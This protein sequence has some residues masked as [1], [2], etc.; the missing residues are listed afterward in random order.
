MKLG[1]TLGWP[2]DTAAIGPAVSRISRLADEA[3]VDSIWITDHFFQIPVTELPREAPML[4][5]YATLAYILGQTRQIHVGALVTCPVYRHPG[6]LLK[7]LTT[8]DVLSG[9]RVTFGIGAGWHAEE[10]RALGIPF[11]PLR[12]RYERLEETLQIAHQM[13][14]GDAS[15]FDGKHYQLAEPINSP[16]AVERPRILIAGGGETKTLRL[17]ARY[18]D[19]CNLF[20]LPAYRQ[21]DL[22]HKL[23]VLRSH[24]RDAGRPYEEIEKTVLTTLDIHGDGEAGRRRVVGRIRELA[25]LGFDHA[26]LMPRRFDWG[27]DIED[28]LAIVDEVH[29]IEPAT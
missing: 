28:A 12:E 27:Q 16:N 5:A 4:E 23:E 18:G 25:A 15:P 19:A 29:A 14:R 22:P 1:I 9:G 7:S 10:A 24:C 2:D 11:P 17:V 20:D 3:G 21:V 6:V 26:I 13:W 8:L